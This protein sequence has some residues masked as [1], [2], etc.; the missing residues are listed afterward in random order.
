MPGRSHTPLVSDFIL[1]HFYDPQAGAGVQYSFTGAVDKPREVRQGGY[2]S[3]LDPISDHWFQIQYFDGGPKL[4]RL[5]SMGNRAGSLREWIDSRTQ[6]PYLRE[7]IPE[8]HPQL[9][10]ARTA[11]RAVRESAK[12]KA[13]RWRGQ[14]DR[15]LQGEP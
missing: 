6:P 8:D 13:Q 2:V 15:L 12:A 10:G 11:Q 3:W 9:M 14:I 1:P 5:G 4:V 7:R